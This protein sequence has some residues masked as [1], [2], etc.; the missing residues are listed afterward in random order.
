M[1]IPDILDQKPNSSDGES[2]LCARGAA[3]GS[4]LLDDKGGFFVDA[5]LSEGEEVTVLRTNPNTQEV[6]VAS[7]RGNGFELK[8]G[9]SERDCVAND[10]FSL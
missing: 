5:A 9:L 3:L 1:T 4:I 2:Y 10:W 6:L 8:E 7:V